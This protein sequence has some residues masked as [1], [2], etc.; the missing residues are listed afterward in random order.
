MKKSE[1]KNIIK[2]LVQECVKESV[3]EMLLES[4]L[5][6]SVISEV[7]SGINK[8]V[9]VEKKVAQPFTIQDDDESDE[10]LR[11][12]QRQNRLAFEN[13]QTK[14]TKINPGE[15]NQ[16]SE[17]KKHLVESIGKSGYSGLGNIFENIKETIPD[18]ISPAAS[19]ANPLSGIDP[20]DPGVDIGFLNPSKMMALVNGKKKE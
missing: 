2:P 19:A 20:S 8:T 3:K 18:E 5:L 15:R 4:G 13:K 6:A 11:Y 12:R 7:V 17:T 1:F 14:S 10:E 16:I 9:L